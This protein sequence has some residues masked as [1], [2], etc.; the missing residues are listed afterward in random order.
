MHNRND[1]F[2]AWGDDIPIRLDAVL[3]T[4]RR[5]LENELPWRTMPLD[6][7]FGDVR[8]I[9]HE[10]FNEG[11]QPDGVHRRE[12]LR[13]VA[14]SHGAFRRSQQCTAE[15]IAYEVEVLAC[16]IECVLR[17]SGAAAGFVEDALVVLR[18][19]LRDVT[20]DAMLAWAGRGEWTARWD[21]HRAY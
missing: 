5:M 14:R 6:D 3:R 8:G 10:L 9:L 13:T 18:A 16:A 2:G 12:Q 21:E 1:A 7:A 17:Q 19:G 4:W 15:H 20:R 11:R